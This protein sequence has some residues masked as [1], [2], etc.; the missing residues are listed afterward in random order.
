MC[1]GRGGGGGG[2]GDGWMFIAVLSTVACDGETLGYPVLF[3][4]TSNFFH[5][6]HMSFLEKAIF[7]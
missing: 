7:I 3:C 4:F 6:E 2:G 5:N 1:V